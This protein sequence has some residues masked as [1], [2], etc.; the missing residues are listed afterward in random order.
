MPFGRKDS[1]LQPDVPVFEILSLQDG[2]GKGPLFH[3]VVFYGLV[4]D[5]RRPLADVLLFPMGRP[6]AENKNQWT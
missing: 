1:I 2:S 3:H 4:E 6:K 5:T